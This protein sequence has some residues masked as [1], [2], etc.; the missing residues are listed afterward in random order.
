MKKRLTETITKHL[1]ACLDMLL[2]RTCIVCGKKLLVDEKHICLQCTID[3]P[4][5]YF[6]DRTH[7]PMADRFNEK[8]QEWLDADTYERYAYASA[9]FFYNEGAEYKNI[10]REL[11]YNGNIPAGRYFAGMLGSRMA[12]REH[13]RD[14]GMVIPVPLHWKR[15]WS[16]GYN[17]AEV[18]AK[19]IAESLGAVMRN[20]ILERVRN[21]KTQ[22][23]LDIEEKAANVKEAF[24]VRDRQILL[25]AIG[26]SCV[27]GNQTGHILLVD[28]VFTTG[29]TL[30]ACFIALRQ[31]LAPE[32][33]ISIATLG[34]VG[35]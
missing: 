5:T 28:D 33:R 14:V 19:E 32:V 18:I 15:E 12:S 20:D 21:T 16:R 11:K 30:N 29:A 35:E 4:L 6:W 22:T 8:L 10:T 2:S 34:F 26:S 1:S 24:A 27:G 7:N 9:L 3:L 25:D 23:R 17:Q 13:F 31:V